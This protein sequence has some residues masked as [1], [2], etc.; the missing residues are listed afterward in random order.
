[1]ADSDLTL[2][3][4][5]AEA[6]GVSPSDAKLP[7]IIGAASEAIASYIGRRLHY[8]AAN[9][10]R[11]AGYVNQVRLYLGVTPV[12]SVAQVVLP[13]GSVLTEAGDDFTLED[14]ATLYRAAGWPFTGLVRAG[15]LYD[16]PAVGTEKRGIVATY[17]GGW[18]TPAQAA[19]GGWAG[20]AR[21]LPFEL[22]EA[23]LQ[24]VAALY[25]KQGADQTVASESLGAY[26]VSYRLP[27]AVGNI[28]DVV[29]ATLDRYRRL[30]P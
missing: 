21:S 29:K 14:A 19:S 1:M 18:V 11:L 7:R 26:S 15:L 10:E 24:T 3:A 27:S 12:L 23:C 9:A 25:A 6:L 4:T 30:V 5:A 22:E 28:P 17:A 2:A 16:M 13:D 20:P 8:A